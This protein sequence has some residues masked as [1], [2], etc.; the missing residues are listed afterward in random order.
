MHHQYYEHDEYEFDRFNLNLAKVNH[1]KSNLSN[2]T[3]KSL[4]KTITIKD[5][6]SNF[7]SPIID[8][9]NK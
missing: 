6:L 3:S 9:A 4:N 7:I 5:F 1:G 2:D 8:N